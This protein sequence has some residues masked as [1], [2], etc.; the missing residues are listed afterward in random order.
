[1]HLVIQLDESCQT[2]PFWLLLWTVYEDTSFPFTVMIM[3]RSLV[4]LA[5]AR[6]VEYYSWIYSTTLDPISGTSTVF[7]IYNL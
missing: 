6:L 2:V 4:S 7:N 5:L 1:M 3:M